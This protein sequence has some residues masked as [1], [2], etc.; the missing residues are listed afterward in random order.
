MFFIFEVKTLTPDKIT[1]KTLSIRLTP[2]MAVKV[3]LFRC[4]ELLE[5]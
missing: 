1:Q 2:D 3:G 4:S 5:S